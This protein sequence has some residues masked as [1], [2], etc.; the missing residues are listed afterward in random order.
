VRLKPLPVAVH[1]PRPA[2]K[3]GET[4]LPRIHSLDAMR[5]VFSV[6]IIIGH[7]LLLLPTPLLRA[8][9]WPIIIYTPLRCGY[10]FVITFFML[11]GFVLALP[12]TTRPVSYRSFIIRRLCR[13]YIPFAAII[14]I[15]FL[16]YLLVGLSPADV[17]D[18]SYHD[19]NLSQLSVF[20][21]WFLG[22]TLLA[23]GLEKHLL[24][25][26]AVW[27]L[28]YE[29]R[30]A[31][32][33]PFLVMLCRRPLTAIVFMVACYTFVSF[34]RVHIGN[35]FIFPA[36]TDDEASTWLTTVYITP[37]FMFGILLAIYG[38]RIRG[39]LD[40]QSTFV[41]VILWILVF[42][43]F[44]FLPDFQIP[45]PFTEFA[46]ALLIL[47]VLSSNMIDDIAEA[48]VLQ[49][50]GRISFSNY[51]IHIPILFVL[52]KLWEGQVALGW[53]CLLCLVMTFPLATLAQRFIEMPARRLAK[54]WIGANP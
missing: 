43:N 4:K 1:D 2:V 14:I 3:D 52:R 35:Y 18:M 28:V 12:Y 46:A 19:K 29:L 47:L 9:G 38:G 33:F 20:T 17:N 26:P 41:R 39:F 53:L 21:P 23:S 15:T 42:V 40:D 22:G 8:Y 27:T 7:F 51:M 31:F 11:S 36:L 25:N 34:A 10:A 54:R 24:L 32:I 30:I 37:C 16:L 45:Q 13:I 50:L 5:G 49:W 44:S 6:V 48:P